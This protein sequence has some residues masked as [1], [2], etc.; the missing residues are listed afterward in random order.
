MIEGT[1]DGQLKTKSEYEQTQLHCTEPC[2]VTRVIMQC[3]TLIV[4]KCNLKRNAPCK[5]CVTKYVSVECYS[6]DA[7]Y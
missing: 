7:C 4:A 1:A 6:F 5:L 3:V 2:K